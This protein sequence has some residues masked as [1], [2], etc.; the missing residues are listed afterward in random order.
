MIISDFINIVYGHEEKI[1][2]ILCGI[3]MLSVVIMS[4]YVYSRSKEWD[5]EE[6]PEF[7]DVPHMRRIVKVLFFFFYL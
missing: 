2:Q 7:R 1:W 6:R 4:C 5:K 3:G